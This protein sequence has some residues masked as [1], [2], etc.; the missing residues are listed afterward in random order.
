MYPYGVHKPSPGPSTEPKI[1]PAAELCTRTGYTESSPGTP[2][3]P[4]NVP[5]AEL[6]TRTGYTSRHSAPKADAR[7]AGTIGRARS[8]GA[9]GR[10]AGRLGGRGL[11][12]E[13]RAYL[14][15]VMCPDRVHKSSPGPPAPLGWRP[16]AWSEPAPAPPDPAG[17]VRSQP[18]YPWV[19]GGDLSFRRRIQNGNGHGVEL[20]GVISSRCGAPTGRRRGGA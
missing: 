17:P 14:P 13:R 3:A 18:G 6:C 7:R 8:G 16:R 12:T 4:A 20:A 1:R 5:A 19:I 9:G 2:T 10:T 11:T 15:R